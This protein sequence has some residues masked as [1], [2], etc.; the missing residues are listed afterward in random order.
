MKPH[1]QFLEDGKFP[2]QL[3]LLLETCRT[4]W[5]F[6]SEEK[7]TKKGSI[8]IIQSGK[9]GIWAALAMYTDTVML[10]FGVKMCSWGIRIKWVLKR[11]QST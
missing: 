11:T 2:S 7:K 4:I 10:K 9:Y 3:W 1:F 8:S 5:E 6:G